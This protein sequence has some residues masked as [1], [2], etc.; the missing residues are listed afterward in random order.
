MFAG[1]AAAA[2][3]ETAITSQNHRSRAPSWRGN[4][5]LSTALSDA[6]LVLVGL[7]IAVGIAGVILPV[8]A[9][10]G[11]FLVPIVI[12]IELAAT[13]VATGAWLAAVLT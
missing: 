8:L 2:R 3:P 5:H 11:F 12:A 7:T 6:G 9:V 10:A 1:A 13:L 4:K